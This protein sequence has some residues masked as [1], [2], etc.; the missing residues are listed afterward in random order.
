[1]PHHEPQLSSLFASQSTVV[2]W[3]DIV[4]HVVGGS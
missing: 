3:C 2:L 4:I 1:M